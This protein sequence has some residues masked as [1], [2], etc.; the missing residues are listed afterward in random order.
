MVPVGAYLLSVVDEQALRWAICALV[1]GAVAILGFG[2]RYHGRP[3]SAATAATGALSGL[4]GGATGMTGPPVIFYELAGSA[5]IERMRASFII[6]FAWVDVIALV[7]FAVTGTLVG[8]ARP[9]RGAADRAVPRRRGRRGAPV[10]PRE[11]GLLPPPGGR[12]P[13]RGGGRQPAALIQ[14]LGCR[15]VERVGFVGLGIMG[16]RMAA[17]LRRAG[18]ELTVFNRTR[19]RADAFAAEHGATVAD[20]PADVGAASDLV[21]T[22]VVDGA[23][24]EAVLL[25]DD[26]AATRAA[27]GT[28]CVDMS[29][30]APGGHAP[31]RRGP[32]GARARLRRRAGERVVA[33]GRGRDADDHGR[34]DRGGLRPRPAAVRGHGRARGPRRR[35]RPRPD[36]Q[37]DQQRGRRDPTR[38]RSPRRSSSAGRRAS[39]SRRSSGSWARRA[40]AAPCSA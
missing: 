7:A 10:R 33:E 16:S 12:D 18:Y 1:F 23:Q 36:R 22:M 21:I 9:R 29:T 26:G 27:E 25:G 13:G 3:S 24:V 6:F 28:L 17:N 30:I 5:P 32:R 20:T 34:R 11:R 2:W 39:T 38:A 14:S 35:A 15:A 31:H 19:E 4:F 37:A 40:A 8:A